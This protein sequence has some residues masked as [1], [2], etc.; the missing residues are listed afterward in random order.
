MK[1][2]ALADNNDKDY[3]LDNKVTPLKFFRP[4][5]EALL[6][7]MHWIWENVKT[8]GRSLLLHSTSGCNRAVAVSLAFL[9][10]VQD[11]RPDVPDDLEAD[12]KKAL[13]HLIDNREHFQKAFKE[14][15]KAFVVGNKQP[16]QSERARR[17]PLACSCAGGCRPSSRRRP[18]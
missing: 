7:A 3:T 15:Q 5:S 2:I 13:D 14:Y 11:S 6:E 17:C 12:Y 18:G 8:N 1:T 16:A 9:L 4:K 10:L